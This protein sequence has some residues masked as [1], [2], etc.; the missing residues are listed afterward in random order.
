[1]PLRGR[2]A[3][4]GVADRAPQRYTSDLRFLFSCHVVDKSIPDFVI[5]WL[6]T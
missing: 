3:V 4:V 5:Y 2:V 6:Q 1:M